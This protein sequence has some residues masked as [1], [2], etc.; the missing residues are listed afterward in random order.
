MNERT[1][2]EE[3]LAEIAQRLRGG[4][5]AQSVPVR[6]LL[7]WFGIRRRGFYKVREV[8]SALRKF[9]LDTSPDFESAYIDS[10]ISFKLSAPTVSATA[11]G[12]IVLRGSAEGSVAAPETEPSP[13]P[14]ITGGVVADP[15]YRIGK[16]KA[17]NQALVAVKPDASLEA[18]TTLMMSKDLSQLPVMQTEFGVKGVISWE[19]IGK[20]Q[21]LGHSGATA[22]DFMEDAVVVS[23][24][25]SLFSVI[26]TVIDNQYVLVK[27]SSTGKL[28]GI[29]TTSDLSLQFRQLGEPFLLLGEIENH[30]RVLIDGVY[31][32]PELIA[33]VD[34][35]DT[36]RSVESVADLS[37]GEY[38][39]LLEN[40]VHWQKLS[41]PID[42]AIFVG[43][44]DGIR[45]LRND[46]M[47]FDPD[48]LAEEDLTLLRHFAS[49]LQMLTT[50]R[51]S[52]A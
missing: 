24:E 33:A 44:L 3:R 28:S 4:G 21:M 19:S 39:R 52:G 12:T 35:T 14:L 16:L 34:P 40:P 13:L 30:I 31:T 6:V 22:K 23:S 46:V 20:R 10:F 51:S 17:A 7:S 18:A 9:G 8:R 27:D 5:T 45:E 48:P 43:Q 25:S 1:T 26:Q 49:F 11:S 50:L 37:F 41:L 36:S 29:V 32:L 47:H 15:T 2:P 42:R 38:L